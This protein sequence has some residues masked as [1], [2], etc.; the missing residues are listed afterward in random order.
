MEG[1]EAS[2]SIGLIGAKGVG[3][4]AFDTR[5]ATGE[6]K[7]VEF[8]SDDTTHKTF[9]VDKHSVRVTLHDI[10]PGSDHSAM[11]AN[12]LDG[13]LVFFSLTDKNSLEAVKSLVE[14]AE[15]R[16]WKKQDRAGRLPMVLV[17][18]KF[19]LKPTV[20]DKEI[21]ALAH[22]VKVVKVSS[23]SGHN[24]TH[25]IEEIVREIRNGG[26]SEKCLIC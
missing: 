26:S 23:A 7:E 17:G 18:S 12:Q 25:A 4:T 10:S 5:V 1:L 3:K 9:V 15:E 19:D 24:V 11:F 14:E 8:G 22:G 13:L 16:G 6:F 20:T 21:E 2:V